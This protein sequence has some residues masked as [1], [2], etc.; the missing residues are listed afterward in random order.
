MHCFLRHVVSISV[1]GLLA[2]G[3]SPALFNGSGDVVGVWKR[4][5]DTGTTVRDQYT[6]RADGT[7][8]FDEFKTNPADEDHV[9]GTWRKEGSQLVGEGI[10][11]R[12]GLRGRTRGT[13]YVNS[14]QFL[15]GALLRESG[16]P[17]IVGVWTGILVNE[18]LD[19]NGQVT[20]SSTTGGR[21][22]FRADHTATAT[23]NGQTR[24]TTWEDKGEN[25]YRV[26]LSS[27]GGLTLS[28]TF[29]LVDDLA[30]AGQI[31]TK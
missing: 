8:A 10:N 25:H 29:T 6:F 21:F 31:Y 4:Y 1:L 9:S 28:T 12:S 7:F 27:G 17:G 5:D 15:P 11:A 26:V 13:Y 23:V 19:G 18:S 30:L 24:E 14:T 16:G 2:C 22:A 3:S 20:S